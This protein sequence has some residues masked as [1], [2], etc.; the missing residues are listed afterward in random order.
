MTIERIVSRGQESAEIIFSG[1]QKLRVSKIVIYEKAIRKGDDIDSELF[2]ELLLLDKKVRIKER[3]LLLLSRRPHGREEL[4][5]KLIQKKFEKDLVTEVLQSFI[6]SGLLND[7]EFSI[8]FYNDRLNRGKDSKRKILHDLRMK[9]IDRKII[10][11]I[12]VLF[13]D[14]EEN[15]SDIRKIAEKKLSSYSYQNKD[16]KTK[17]SN[18]YNFLLSKGYDYEVIRKVLAG[19][20]DTVDD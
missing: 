14:D 4:K 2:S 9:G 19:I 3:A 7:K 16:V 20:F 5:L 6:D 10:D 12:R 11:E 8:L 13:P 17:K 18:L 15:I 1:G